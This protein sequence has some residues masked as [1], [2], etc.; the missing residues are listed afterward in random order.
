MLAEHLGD[1][2]LLRCLDL[3]FNSFDN[4]GVQLL[5]NGMAL[6]HVLEDIELLP[7]LKFTEA[8]SH[9]AYH[10]DANWGGRGRLLRNIIMPLSLWPLVLERPKK[11]KK[12]AVLT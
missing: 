3:Y 11:P 12:Y 4:A 7:Q 2:T 9:L 6:N 5:A 1:M 8:W 10:L